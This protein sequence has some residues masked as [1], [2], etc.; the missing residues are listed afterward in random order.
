MNRYRVTA[1]PSDPRADEPPAFYNVLASK[2]PHAERMAITAYATETGLGIA[3]VVARA[4][5]AHARRI[6]PAECFGVMLE[7]VVEHQEGATQ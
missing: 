3:S 1:R 6:D 5:N 2:K 7:R 4:D